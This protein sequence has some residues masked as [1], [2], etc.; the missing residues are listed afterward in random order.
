MVALRY[1]GVMFLLLA[2]VAGIAD[3]DQ[4]AN[5]FRDG[6][7]DARRWTS[8]G[9]LLIAGLPPS[10]VERALPAG[11]TVLTAPGLLT[12]P[13]VLA[14]GALG[15]LLLF[16]SLVGHLRGNPGVATD[17]S[18]GG[19]GRNISSQTADDGMGTKSDP[20]S[21][22]IDKLRAL[23][24]RLDP[25]DREFL[26]AALELLETPP[27]PLRLAAIVFVC[28]AFTT[29]LAWGYF[30]YLDIHA[31][32]PGRIQPSGRSKTVQPLEPGRIVQIAVENGSDVKAGDVLLELDPTETGADQEAQARELDSMRAEAERRRAAIAAAMDARFEPPPISFP[33]GTSEPT[34][35]R[36][37]SVIAAE[38][39]QIAASRASLQAQH[40]EHRAT[41]ERLV[42][43]ISARERLLALTKERVVMRKTLNDKGSLSRALVIDSLLQYETQVTTQVGEQGQLAEIEATLKKLERKIEE[44]T[45]QFIAEQTQKLAEAERKVDRLQQELIKA[46]SKNERA[47]LRASISGTVQQL[48]VTTVGQVVT[49]GQSLMT[50]VPVSGAIEIEAMIQ[51]QD[52]GFVEAGQSAVVKIESFPFTRYGTI[53]GTVTKVSRDAVDERDA[54]ALGDPGSSLKTQS[55]TSG[56]SSSKGQSLVFPATIHLNRRSIN[57]EGKDIPLSPGMAVTVEIRTGERRAIDYILS[58]LREITG[59]WGHER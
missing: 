53:D 49:T 1:G 12:T 20:G 4:L 30:G 37:M 46:H 5:L 59:S 22:S 24:V 57:I 32:A 39:G 42:A 26:P 21:A 47:T 38:L 18:P 56:A 14:F 28:V 9:S 50:I 6:D 44:T 23:R 33:P 48:A 43:S 2:L 7:P 19:I 35:R 36:E 52:I 29:S 45:S 31:V 27:A 41:Q 34:Q 17:R 54:N 25:V 13:I 58:P 3:F 15:A 40:A 11:A 55:M 16:L 51:N 8:L 10:V